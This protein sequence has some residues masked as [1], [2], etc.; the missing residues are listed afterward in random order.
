MSKNHSLYR[1]RLVDRLRRQIKRCRQA[2]ALEDGQFRQQ[3]LNSAR[4]YS[5][6]R[7]HLKHLEEE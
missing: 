6:R 3:R 5:R 1:Q 7:K 4:T 2:K